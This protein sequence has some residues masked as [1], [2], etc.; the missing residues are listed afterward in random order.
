VLPIPASYNGFIHVVEGATLV[1]PERT[2][3]QPGDVVWLDYPTVESGTSGLRVEAQTYARFLVVTGQPVREK[4]VAQGPFV[5][6]STDE[7]LHAYADYRAGRF[8]GPTP[9]AMEIL[10]AD[11]EMFE[12][13]SKGTGN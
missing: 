7:I 9:A 10:E 5:M 2:L 3:S 4:V 1:G 13:L 11:E 6:N 12:R 8:G